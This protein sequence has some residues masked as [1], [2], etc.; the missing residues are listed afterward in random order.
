MNGFLF[1]WLLFVL[2]NL[3]KNTSRFV[4]YLTLL[5]KSN[6]LE[7]VHGH[8]LVHL[9]KLKLLALGCA[10]EICSLFSCPVGISMV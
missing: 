7:R 4:G 6:E 8:H 1:F 3:L 5:K 10:K 9:R 2:G